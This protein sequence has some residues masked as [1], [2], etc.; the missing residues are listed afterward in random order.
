[1]STFGGWRR[2]LDS[3]LRPRAAEQRLEEEMAFHVARETEKN[4][5]LGMSTEEARRQALIDFGMNR[6]PDHRA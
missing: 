2:R 1:M 3:L 4:V 6:K 5:G